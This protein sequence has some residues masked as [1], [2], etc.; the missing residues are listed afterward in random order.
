MNN[1]FLWN[2]YIF[3]IYFHVSVPL[4]EVLTWELQDIPIGNIILCIGLHIFFINS[5][6]ILWTPHAKLILDWKFRFV[7]VHIF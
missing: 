6:L 3:E 2:I 7:I 1:L 4:T 5:I